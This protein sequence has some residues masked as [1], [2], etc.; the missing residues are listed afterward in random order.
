M[1]LPF[2]VV[3]VTIGIFRALS[4]VVSIAV[5]NPWML[6]VSAVSYLLMYYYYRKATNTLIETNRLDS[7]FRGPLH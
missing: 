7:I 5:I 4:V 2:N 6:V 3:L 1:I